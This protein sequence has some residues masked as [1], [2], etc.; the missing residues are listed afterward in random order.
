MH[1]HVILMPGLEP[2]SHV[3]ILGKNW[4][5][6]LAELLSFMKTRG[7]KFRI[8]DLSDSFIAADA[9]ELLGSEIISDLGGTLKI[10]RITAVIPAKSVEDAFIKRRKDV[11]AEIKSLLSSSN[12]TDAIFTKP[13]GKYVFG[14]SIYP[15]N[16]RF[17][18]SSRIL[19]RFIGSYFKK[20]LV[21]RGAK[22][23]FMGTPRGREPPQL[24][25]VE[26]LKKGLIEKSAEVLFCIG[27]DDAF[28]SATTAVHNPFEF[29]KRDVQRPVQRKIF[30]IPP[31][32]AR[33]M[34]NLTSCLP[35]A[36]LLDPFCGVG[37]IL[38]EAMLARA[39]V[40][41]IDNNPW[42]VEASSKNL[43]WLQREYSLGTVKCRVM[44]GD[45]RSLTQEV[46]EGSIDCIATEP[47]LGPALR[48]IPTESYAKRI[49]SGLEPLYD[50]FLREAY[51]ALK[52]GGKAVFV[53]PYIRTRRGAF[54]SL[55]IRERA[56]SIGFRTVLPFEEICANDSWAKGLA[57]ASSLV[58]I[59]ERHKIGR[60]IH[61]LQK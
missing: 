48:D 18:R 32:V 16:R 40:V 13:S 61:I 29:Q 27:R 31:R 11:Q 19:Q 12:L 37:T 51:K 41:G 52:T 49:I 47:A 46:R 17:L 45:A 15:E 53:T 25:N 30:S 60:E 39:Q 21:L 3:F 56:I 2:A 50:G 54:Q 24:T 8:A 55:N 22:A 23:K 33:I 43:E 9:G 10:G 36:T 28:L 26:I 57:G 34:V 7:R 20:E 5:L 42:C 1:L 44:V 6:S 4:Q 38:Q 35:G 58:D 59:E 14:V